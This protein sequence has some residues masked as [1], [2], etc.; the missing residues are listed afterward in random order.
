MKHARDTTPGCAH[1][2]TASK[3]LTCRRRTIIICTASKYCRAIMRI[4]R[5]IGS[6]RCL[7]RIRVI[8][9]RRNG[10]T[11]DN[12]LPEVEFKTGDVLIIEGHPDDIQAAEIEIMSGL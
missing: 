9:L 11:S 10:V 6:L 4:G 1:S 5:S 7:G 2:S 8:G 12:P 3:M